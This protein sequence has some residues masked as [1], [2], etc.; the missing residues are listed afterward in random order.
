MSNFLVD[1]AFGAFYKIIIK[2]FAKHFNKRQSSQ[3]PQFEIRQKHIQN[4]KLLTTREELLK[5]L[6]KEGIVAEF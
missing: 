2:P 6:P 5:L 3:I 1:K 4:T